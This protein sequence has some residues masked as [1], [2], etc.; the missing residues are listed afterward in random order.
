[1]HGWSQKGLREATSRRPPLSTS[2][3]CSLL[4][5]LLKLQPEQL[6][7]GINGWPFA[8]PQNPLTLSFRFSSQLQREFRDTLKG[9]QMGLRLF[10]TNCKAQG[11][12]L[13]RQPGGGRGSLST[14]A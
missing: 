8:P 1:M 2:L 5:A 6:A 14:R 11:E 10:L 4:G 12:G 13:K 7:E 9:S 3:F